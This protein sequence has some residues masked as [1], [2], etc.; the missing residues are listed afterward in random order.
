MVAQNI[1]DVFL[2]KARKGKIPV[3]IHIV[4]G[5][6]INDATVISYDSFVLLVEKD[7]KQMLLYKHAISSITP[8]KNIDLVADINRQGDS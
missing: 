1:Q 3:T 2:N 8:S 4:N 5:F 6:Q 7:A